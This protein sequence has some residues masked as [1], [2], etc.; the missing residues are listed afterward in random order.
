[1]LGRLGYKGR[2]QVISRDGVKK[3]KAGNELKLATDAKR[4]K[5]AFFRYVN[6]KGHR[7]ETVAQLFSGNGEM[8]T[9][10]KK[11]RSAQFL[12][13]PTLLPKDTELKP[14]E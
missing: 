13:R 12:L 8:I 11:G 3:T 10:D 4:N 2:V 7:K 6:S 1:M 9:D 5:K 14:T